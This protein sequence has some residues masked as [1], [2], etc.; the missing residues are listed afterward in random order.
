MAKL[1]NLVAQRKA[2]QE[3]LT[4][5]VS[6]VHNTEEPIDKWEAR[7]QL[8]KLEVVAK[9]FKQVQPEIEN[10]SKDSE[11]EKQERTDFNSLHLK[12]WARLQRII[13]N[14]E[15]H[16]QKE[17]SNSNCH[18][19]S[20]PVQLPAVNI[21]KFGKT[22]ATTHGWNSEI[23][24]YHWSTWINAYPTSKSYTISSHH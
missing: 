12:T 18:A 10:L 23:V 9:K 5:I 21:P 11:K 24:F 20:P 7:C 1:N 3:E 19:V 17:L 8:S 2:Q 14:A 22:A 15:N 13:E 4:S 6:W 16:D